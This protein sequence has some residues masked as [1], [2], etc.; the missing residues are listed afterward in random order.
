MS[1]REGG[2]MSNPHRL[3]RIWALTLVTLFAPLAQAE[4][5]R[6]ITWKDLVPELPAGSPFGKLSKEQ[7]LVLSDIASVRDRQARN[8]KVSPIDIE[9]EKAGT[10]KLEQAG[11]DVSA[12]LARRKEIMEQKRLRAQS[13]NASLD[14]QWVRIPG[15]LLPLEY[16][17]KEVSEFLLV[18]WVGACIHT[19]PPP[20]NQIVHVKAEKP[21]LSTGAYAPVWVTGRLSVAGSRKSLYLV[22]GKSDIDIGYTLGAG[23]VEPYKE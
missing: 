1:L 6:Q 18:P 15:Y 16:S 7:L 11:V 14:G 8:E 21:F 22:D 12:L 4:S 2:N 3:L 5:P 17:G 23:V 9:D 13:A 20:P 19:P 10:R